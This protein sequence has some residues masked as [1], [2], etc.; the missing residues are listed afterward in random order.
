MRYFF[1]SRQ[2]PPRVSCP[3]AGKGIGEAT[4]KLLAA[5]GAAIVVCDVDAAAA[6]QVAVAIT[7]SLKCEAQ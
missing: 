7:V 4:A 6:K 2:A 1:H 3:G 5:H